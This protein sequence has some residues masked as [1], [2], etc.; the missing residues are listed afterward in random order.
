MFE[1]VE[2]KNALTN[3]SLDNDLIMLQSGDSQASLISLSY[4]FRENQVLMVQKLVD[5]LFHQPVSLNSV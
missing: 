5:T 3:F 1:S 4:I 2:A